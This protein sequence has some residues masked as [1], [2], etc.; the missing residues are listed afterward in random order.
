MSTEI[1]RCTG[2]CCVAFML[3]E[4]PEFYKKDYEV[5]LEWVKDKAK[6]RPSTTEIEIISPMLIYHGLGW[7]YYTT[8]TFLSEKEEPTW[9]E[10]G[11]DPPTHHY[12]CKHF[13]VETRD[14]T[15]YESRPNMCR[16]Y[17]YDGVCKL[18]GC[19]FKTI[20][21]SEGK[22]CGRSVSNK[23][24]PIGPGKK[25]DAGGETVHEVVPGLANA[26]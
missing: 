26:V 13:D 5:Y 11:C 23:R 16:L 21:S 20:E 6:S 24:K 22:N 2:S 8:D 1:Q 19:T 15:I 12:T 14:C 18:K 3:P 10:D 9:K 4:G 17:P 25:N 7:W